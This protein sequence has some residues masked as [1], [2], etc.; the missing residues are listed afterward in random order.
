MN[1]QEKINTLHKA[2]IA[3]TGKHDEDTIIALRLIADVITSLEKEKTPYPTNEK[4][5]HTP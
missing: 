5:V 3:L 1:L 2:C 4:E